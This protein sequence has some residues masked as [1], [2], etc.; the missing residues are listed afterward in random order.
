MLPHM[1]S[2]ALTS[3]TT[4]DLAGT[5]QLCDAD[6]GNACPLALPGDVHSALLAAKLIPDPFWGLNEEQ[7]QWV[8]E[9]DWTAARTV[10][11]DA[12][13]LTAPSI[14][15]NA[16]VID[17]LC[18]VVINGTVAGEAANH[19]RRHRF[20]VRHLLRPGANRIE[21]RFH[22][23]VLAM[24]RL[25]A[26]LP[27]P[28]PCQVNA[29]G[30]KIPHWN[31]IRKPGCHAGWDWGIPIQ[32]MGVMGA[33]ALHATH[34]AR[35]EHVTTVQEHHAGTVTVHVSA[36][37][38]APAAGHTIVHVK[39]AGQSVEVPVALAAGTTTATATITIA[40]P[41]LWWP[42]GH[43]SQPLYDLCV[44]AGDEV[45]RK[46]LGLR[47]IN[48]LNTPDAIGRPL[49]IRVNGREIFCKGA[50]WI[51]TDALPARQAQHYDGLIRSAKLAHMNMIRVWGGGQWE[52]DRF[53]ELCDEHGI[54][55]WHD[56]MFACSLYPADDAF[57]DE[58]RA[59][60]TYQVKRLRDHACIA[61]WCGDNENVGALNWFKES[62]ASR[63]RYLID[64]VRLDDARGLA[65][66]AADP[67]RTYWPSSP[68]AGPGDFSDTWHKDG[69][70]DMHYWSVWHEGKSF[71][72]Y[73]AV[74]PRFCSEFGY[75][76]FNSLESVRTYCP[77]E[78]MNI[79]APVMEWH[80]RN[81]GGNRRINEMFARYF[82]M[83]VGFEQ[84]LYLSQVQQAIAIKTA[85]EYWRSLR[86]Q[87]MGTIYWQLND[88]WPV[89]SWA[90]VEYGG[91]WKQ[92]H[93][94]AR[95]FFQPVAV[96]IQQRLEQGTEI[97]EAWAINDN[98]SD[99][100]IAVELALWDFDGTPGRSDTVRT[101]IAAGSA[102]R[103]G[104]WPV[105]HFCADDAARRS[106]FLHATLSGA[107]GREPVAHS[108][109]HVFT[110]FKR[111]R[112]ADASV[113]MTVSGADVTLCSDKPA[114]FVMATA[115]SVAG[116]FDDN[117]ITLLPGH[118]RTL[119]RRDD[120]GQ[121]VTLPAGGV[122]IM[123]LRQTY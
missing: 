55:L 35:I 76:S 16:D 121:A 19:F 14:Y 47:V 41:Q 73:Y 30:P 62:K 92:L 1:T 68:C 22:S 24:R 97:V 43:G 90:S 107:V 6:G 52:G 13:L 40:D 74:K 98:A 44:Q 25:A 17:T 7:V 112:L 26:A 95:R 32:S 33:F 66:Q 39:L 77:P 123:H 79:T 58:V 54:L 111:C 11:I 36:E 48:V 38:H 46:R 115:D 31:L 81:E 86:P 45:V 87:C 50:N 84:T 83:P 118:P 20:E 12:A 9:R 23:S 3:P 85:V 70:G 64:W 100:E 2:A 8:G 109:T 75:Q 110:E 91:R 10:Q 96:V 27:Y 120:H 117:S 56:F 106:T 57:L 51:P 28:V 78:D 101:S 71:D 59:E 104:S 37:L 108:N 49:T 5:W 94:H 18:T 4:L 65:A 119:A 82:R 88:I 21:L 34:R 61:L 69:S 113:A 63:D 80:Q 89:A 15:L 105:A 116:E 60:T 103:L 67:T 93:H 99:G 42:N 29:Y 114:F 72:A 53:Y 102:V 122:R